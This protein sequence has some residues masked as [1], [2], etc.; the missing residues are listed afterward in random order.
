MSDYCGTSHLLYEYRRTIE[1]DELF[2]RNK[3]L[4]VFFVSFISEEGRLG[5]S[6]L[7]RYEFTRAALDRCDWTVAYPSGK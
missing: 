5:D 3:V 4:Q 2:E 1:P 6:I 7:A